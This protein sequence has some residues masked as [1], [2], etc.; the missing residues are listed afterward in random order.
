MATQKIFKWRPCAPICPLLCISGYFY[1][2][3]R[4]SKRFMTLQI[5]SKG[6]NLISLVRRASS[7]NLD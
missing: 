1:S 2:F 3:G 5:I 6:L 7:T 4:D